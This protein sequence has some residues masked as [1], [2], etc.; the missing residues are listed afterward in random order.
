MSQLKISARTMT[1]KIRGNVVFEER[2]IE[3]VSLIV[4]LT[5]IMDMSNESHTK[6]NIKKVIDMIGNLGPTV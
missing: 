2:A 1:T 6:A 5:H 4:T 3:A